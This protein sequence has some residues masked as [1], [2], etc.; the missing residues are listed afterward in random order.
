ME[1]LFYYFWWAP[2]LLVPIGWRVYGEWA[3]KKKERKKKDIFNLNREKKK[4]TFVL[5]ERK[6]FFVDSLLEYYYW[7]QRMEFC[8]WRYAIGNAERPTLKSKVGW[9]DILAN[10]TH[11][12][13][14]HNNTGGPS[15][16]VGPNVV[17]YYYYYCYYSSFYR[18]HRSFQLD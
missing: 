13:Y 14:F 6:G 2:L 17:R 11:Q 9:L 15:I 7:L 8:Y 10:D 4:E 1:L 18:L 12:F 5:S 3:Q 16:K